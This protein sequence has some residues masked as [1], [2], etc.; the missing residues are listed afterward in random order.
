MLFSLSAPPL[1]PCAGPLYIN[2]VNC[3]RFFSA[4]LNYWI[5]GAHKPACGSNIGVELDIMTARCKNARRV[6]AN[7]Q[8]RSNSVRGVHFT[9][10]RCRA[11]AFAGERDQDE[12]LF[13]SLRNGRVRTLQFL[14]ISRRVHS[15][16]PNAKCICMSRVIPQA[17]STHKGARFASRPADE[18]ALLFASYQLRIVRAG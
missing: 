17:Q 9:P 11:F 12:R 18:A 14:C 7:Y 1:R 2:G 4:C 10:S 3:S 15:A 13:A 8:P 16:T 6:R 5:C